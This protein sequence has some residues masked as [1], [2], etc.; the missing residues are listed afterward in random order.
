MASLNVNICDVMNIHLYST[1][2][3]YCVIYHIYMGIIYILFVV[4]SLQV[5]SVSVK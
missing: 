4:L 1:V 5:P 2:L 3:H